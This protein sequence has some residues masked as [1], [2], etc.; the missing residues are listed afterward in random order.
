MAGE[1]VDANVALATTSSVAVTTVSA[2]SVCK[3][4]FPVTVAGPVVAAPVAVGKLVV[5]LSVVALPAIVVSRL[6]AGAKLV[7]VGFSVVFSAVI[8]VDSSKT[9]DVDIL[10]VLSAVITTS[11][12]TMQFALN[13]CLLFNVIF[14]HKI[15]L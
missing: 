10:S 14:C 3:D 7:N 2:V 8:R 4:I 6:A 11:T 1:V 9:A 15:V 13:R 12:N 5:V